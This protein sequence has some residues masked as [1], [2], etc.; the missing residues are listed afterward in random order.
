MFGYSEGLFFIC[1][2]CNADGPEAE[3][4]AEAVD[5]WNRRARLSPKDWL[6]ACKRRRGCVFRRG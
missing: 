3:S 5:A 4:E 6:P 1:E 2:G